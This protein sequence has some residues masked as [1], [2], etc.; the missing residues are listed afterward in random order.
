MMRK[1]ED[2]EE[3]GKGR[4]KGPFLYSLRQDEGK[5]YAE[6]SDRRTAQCGRKRSVIPAVLC[7]F[8]SLASNPSYRSAYF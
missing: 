3:A 8:L 1:N 5:K 6:K 2:C 4:E 7:H